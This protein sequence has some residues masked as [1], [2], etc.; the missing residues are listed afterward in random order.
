MPINQK[1]EELQSEESEECKVTE[2]ESEECKYTEENK[3]EIIKTW[4]LVEGLEDGETDHTYEKFIDNGDKTRVIRTGGRSKSMEYFHTLEEYDM[5]LAGS[6][7]F[8]WDRNSKRYLYY[9]GIKAL[10]NVTE[11][12]LKSV[13]RTVSVPPKPSKITPIVIDWKGES[14]DDHICALESSVLQAASDLRDTGNE[15]ISHENNSIAEVVPENI[16][17][18]ESNHFVEANERKIC[19]A[20]I[21]LEKDQSTKQNSSKRSLNERVK[22]NDIGGN[23]IPSTPNFPAVGNLRDWLNSGG[24]LYSPRVSTTPSFGSYIHGDQW[25]STNTAGNSVQ[26]QIAE[27]KIE[28]RSLSA[29]E[30]DKKVTI[31]RDSS[32]SSYSSPSVSAIEKENWDTPL[33]DPELLASFEKA[34]EQLSN[35]EKCWLSVIEDSSHFL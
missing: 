12:T 23:S 8:L 27:A 34:L 1:N 25:S 18:Q 13:I 15:I 26:F 19:S 9:L 11:F 3:A 10:E 31:I 4:E 30:M 17:R 29:H 32:V 21:N 2:E 28:V 5:I 33:F 16:S 35:E 14:K 24:L 6:K 20:D 22:I 7:T